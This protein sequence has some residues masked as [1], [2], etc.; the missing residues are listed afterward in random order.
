[1]SIRTFLKILLLSLVVFILA[2]V[3][4]RQK[5]YTV[6]GYSTFSKKLLSLP[7]LSNGKL[8]V[9]EANAYFSKN[10]WG[11]VRLVSVSPTISPVT[12]EDRYCGSPV[13]GST[14]YKGQFSLVFQDQKLDLGE[15]AFSDG[16]PHDGQL[17][18]YKLDFASDR[19][20]VA[21]FQY[22]SC[23]VD[24]LSLYGLGPNDQLTQYSF[25]Y[26]TGVVRERIP[27]ER[28][29]LPE[30]PTNKILVTTWYD[31]TIEN[32]GQKKAKWVFNESASS[33]DEI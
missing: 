22:G 23:N 19:D 20:F 16:T 28:W 25:K 27:V 18:L 14:S 21:L 32:S 10:K 2:F 26:K 4:L 15:L 31:N 17:R 7:V 13:V 5:S 12:K 24:Y 11:M 33:F 30:A 9:S 29:S 3:G 6:L 8:I 1:M